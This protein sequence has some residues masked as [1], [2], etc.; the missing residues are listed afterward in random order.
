[1]RR[2][3]E[4][5]IKNVKISVIGIKRSINVKKFLTSQLHGRK[6]QASFFG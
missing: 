6:I 3:G 1:M 2:L 5:N 4:K